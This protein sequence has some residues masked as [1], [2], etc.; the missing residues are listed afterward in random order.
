MKKTIYRG[1]CLIPEEGVHNKMHIIIM[2]LFSLPN[3]CLILALADN[4]IDCS[5]IANVALLAFS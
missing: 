4:S 5:L 3:C 1:D 2:S